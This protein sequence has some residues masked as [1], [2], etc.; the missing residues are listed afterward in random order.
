[1]S[2]VSF[3]ALCGT[4]GAVIAG[5]FAWLVQRSKG[6]SDVEVAVISEWKALFSGVSERLATV[7]REFAEY[8]MKVSK[9]FEEMREN[10]AREKEELR[11]KHR[12]EMKAQ[13][14][15]NEGLQRQIAQN[16]QS[17]AQLLGDLSKKGST[18]GK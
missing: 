17:G 9:D 13:R 3:G 5:I 6:Q 12:A 18:D 8:R 14:E 2:D 15:L 1:M 4:I 11:Q 10:H 7:E 16:S